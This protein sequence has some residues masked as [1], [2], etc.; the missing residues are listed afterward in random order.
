MAHRSGLVV[1]DELRLVIVLDRLANQ[2]HCLLEMSR[3]QVLQR[4]R[5]HRSADCAQSLLHPGLALDHRVGFK[6]LVAPPPLDKGPK[7]LK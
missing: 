6:E 5:G 1:N 4:Y 3:A 2:E 7:Y